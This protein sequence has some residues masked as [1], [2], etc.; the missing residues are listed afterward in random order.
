M[1]MLNRTAIGGIVVVVAFLTWTTLATTE[2][3][4]QLAP[5]LAQ[6]PE[7]QTYVGIKKCASCHIN[8]YMTYRKTKHAKSF[9]LL[10]A[11]YKTD[12]SCLEC[13]TTGYGEASGYKDAS[14]PNLVGTAC[15]ACHGPGS[16]HAAIAG[17]FGKKKLTEAEEK[18]VRD[19]IF[20]I[21]PD[22]SCVKCHTTKAHKEHAKYDK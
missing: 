14:T 9:D 15:E 19:S 20:K 21:N 17:T 13:H 1:S 2:E 5:A 18:T 7:G 10:S 22:N 4:A 11:K 6:P 12:A 3:P 16:E 8:Q